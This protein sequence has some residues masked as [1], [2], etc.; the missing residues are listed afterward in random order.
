MEI[1]IQNSQYL[2]ALEKWYFCLIIQE[3]REEELGDPKHKNK[4]QPLL[5][6]A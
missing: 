1:L 5:C 4:A 2:P 6:Q 3:S